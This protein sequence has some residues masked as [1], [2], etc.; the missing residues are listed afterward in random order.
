MKI[1]LLEDVKNIGKKN[2]IVDVSDGYA[3][4]FLIKKKLAVVHSTG[5]NKSLI[6]NL[7]NID[8]NYKEEVNAA[9]LV[10]EE[11]ESTT[12]DFKLKTNNGV[13]YGKI[14]V[15]EIIDK[16]NKNKKII[17]KYMFI[18]EHNW[19]LGPNSINLK[20]HKDVIAILKINIEAD[21]E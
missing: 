16:V 21:N 1:I 3:I 20:L 18:N 8:K 15:K 4:N 19:S 17:N 13:P 9:I 5:T 7:E 14:S 6:K 12:F 10:K 2:D 11:I